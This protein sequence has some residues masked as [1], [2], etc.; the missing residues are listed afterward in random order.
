MNYNR[1]TVAV[2]AETVKRS[3]EGLSAF[4][5]FA[6]IYGKADFRTFPLRRGKRTMEE[7]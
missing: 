6:G 3:I 5:V 7:E 4:V 1:A 2:F